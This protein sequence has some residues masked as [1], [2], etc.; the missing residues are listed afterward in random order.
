[1][2]WCRCGS[3]CASSQSCQTSAEPVTEIGMIST[4][5]SRPIHLWTWS[6]V[7]RSCFLVDLATHCP[8][9]VLRARVVTGEFVYCKPVANDYQPHCKCERVARRREI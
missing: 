1:M 3:T 6:H 9:A 2:T 4:A 5:R 7:A 8:F